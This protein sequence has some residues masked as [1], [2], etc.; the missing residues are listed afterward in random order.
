[1]DQSAEAYQ[2]ALKLLQARKFRQAEE[3][4]INFSSRHAQ[5]K[6]LPNAGYWLGETYYSQQRYDDAILTFQDVVKK[7]PGHA[8]AAAALLK[9]AYSYERLADASNARFYLQRL[10]EDYPGSEPAALAKS[11]LARLR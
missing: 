2:N 4:F 9:T 11:A 6:F 1:M 7:Y 8:K 10:L 5:S 3:A